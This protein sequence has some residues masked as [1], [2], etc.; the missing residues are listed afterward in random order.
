MSERVLV[1]STGGTIASTAE[2]G[3]ATPTEPGEHL[4]A[5]VPDLRERVRVEELA[6]RPS[7]D[8]DFAVLECL[9]ERVRAHAADADTGV[10]VTHGTDTM[11]ESAYY[12]GLV[13]SGGPPV[14]FTGA[15]R[16]PDQ[17]GADGPANLATA[18][19]AVE[20]PTLREAGG[21]YVCLNGELHAARDAVKSH[22]WRPDAFASPGKGPVATRGP[23]GFERYRALGSRAA[24][25]DPEGPPEADIAV[26]T[27]G[28]GVGR[29]PVD[30]AVEA[31][32][33]G[34]VL[35]ATGLGNAP[36][37]VAAAVGDAVAAGVPVV[38]T[39][40]CHAGGVAAVYGGGG[41]HA[42]REAGAVLA[43][44]LPAPKARIKLLVA[45]AAGTDPDEAFADG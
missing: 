25:F 7:P 14:A 33:D 39:T 41:G 15:Q 31:G 27:T 36:E 20:E 2:D 8:V 43:G 18:V 24:T 3:A 26:V 10:V 37:P 13:R 29:G 16:R 42:L 38:V 35:Q 1:C 40:R 44:D 34:I 30:R 21:V 23:G 45:L 11:A 28:I 19:S 5:A 22:A 6:R 32:C 17:P 4:V 9:R 12:L